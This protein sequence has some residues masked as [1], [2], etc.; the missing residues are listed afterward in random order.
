MKLKRIRLEFEKIGLVFLI[1]FAFYIVLEVL[2]GFLQ[3]FEGYKL[4]KNLIAVGVL[5]GIL[6]NILGRLDYFIW[7]KERPF[8]IKC[9]IGGLIITLAEFIAGLIINIALGW[10]NWDYSHLPLGELF[11]G[12][13]TPVYT[14]LWI[15]ASPFAFWIESV[16]DTIHH[17]YYG[18]R[19]E[20]IT[21][22]DLIHSYKKL[23]FYWGKNT[24]IK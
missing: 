20:F 1:G 21:F 17:N 19:K 2:W 10:N 16:F 24:F 11:M 9:L 14:I 4:F 6:A 7:F 23:L 5:G 8:K 12:Q 3:D 22:E 15:L 18:V 13:I